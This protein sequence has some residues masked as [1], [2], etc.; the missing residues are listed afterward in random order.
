M[1]NEIR[2]ITPNMIAE[3][4]GADPKQLRAYMRSIADN[5]AGKGGRWLLTIDEADAIK[6]GWAAKRS[7]QATPIAF[8]A[9]AL[10]S[11]DEAA[12]EAKPTNRRAKR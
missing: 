3:E 2:N 6:R 9:D 1:S 8:K 4:L 11:I 10:A 7:I 12:T 5:R